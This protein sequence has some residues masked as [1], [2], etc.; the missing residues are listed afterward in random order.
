ML[1]RSVAQHTFSA[2]VPVWKN[3]GCHQ[4]PKVQEE[5]HVHCLEDETIQSD[6]IKRTKKHDLAAIRDKGW[7][8][9]Y[10]MYNCIIAKTL[11]KTIVIT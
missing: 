10:E 7:S 11:Q 1:L 2:E 6:I 9:Q 4:S 5:A 8:R 3:Y